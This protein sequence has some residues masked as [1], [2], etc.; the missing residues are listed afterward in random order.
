[1][2][3]PIGFSPQRVIYYILLL[4][5][6][7]FISVYYSISGY[8][9]KQIRHNRN[10]DK[11]KETITGVAIIFVN[12]LII[13]TFIYLFYTWPIKYDRLISH[14]NVFSACKQWIKFNIDSGRH[15]YA[16]GIL[17]MLKRFTINYNLIKR[18]PFW[19][20]SHKLSMFYDLNCRK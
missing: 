14:W 1:M 8:I 2:Y 3:L 15:R 20:N 10:E 12:P 9:S 19:K 18:K 17:T 4:L 16:I 13:Y 6:L 5:S 7:W 11:R